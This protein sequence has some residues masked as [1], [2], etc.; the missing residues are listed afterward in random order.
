MFT[1]IIRWLVSKGCERNYSP[2]PNKRFTVSLKP[3][4]FYVY[5]IC[6]FIID[7]LL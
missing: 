6:L 2:Y 4:F 3:L 1:L 5:Y 7:R